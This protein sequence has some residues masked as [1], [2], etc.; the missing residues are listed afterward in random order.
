[1]TKA[2]IEEILSRVSKKAK[3]ARKRVEQLE[4]RIDDGDPA[5]ID[6]FFEIYNQV[7]SDAEGLL[8]AV[9]GNNAK[10]I[11]FRKDSK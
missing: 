2:P 11:P 6:E 1:M 5:A 3:A 8:R 4:Q 7:A 10:V 9:E